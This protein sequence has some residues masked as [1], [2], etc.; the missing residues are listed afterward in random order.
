MYKGRQVGISKCEKCH[1][2]IMQQRLAY[3]LKHFFFLSLSSSIYGH[4]EL[5]CIMLQ[6]IYI[7]ANYYIY[8]FPYQMAYR[9]AALMSHFHHPNVINLYDCFIS[10][11]VL[12]I[13]MEYA[14]GGTLQMFLHKKDGKLLTQVVSIPTVGISDD[15]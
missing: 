5:H 6:I 2:F 8:F 3:F 11:R 15:E 12:C 1:D 9:E 13:V 4:K 14:T 7:I 10:G